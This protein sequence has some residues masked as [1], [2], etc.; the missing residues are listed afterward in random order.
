MTTFVVTLH[1]RCTGLQRANVCRAAVLVMTSS[2]QME[3]RTKP[4]PL[5]S[6]DPLNTNPEQQ[7]HSGDGE[8]PPCFWM[9][10]WQPAEVAASS[11]TRPHSAS[12]STLL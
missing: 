1:R 12:L 9:L 5:S 7:Q 4:A 8:Q 6:D 10:A 11:L 2:I 3:E